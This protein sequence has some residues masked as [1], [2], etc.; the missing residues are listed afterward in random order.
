MKSLKCKICG[1]NGP[2]VL[3]LWVEWVMLPFSLDKETLTNFLNDSISGRIV[4]CEIYYDRWWRVL[5]YFGFY[6][7]TRRISSGEIVFPIH[8]RF[9]ITTHWSQL[10]YFTHIFLNLILE[11]RFIRHFSKN[12]I[13]QRHLNKGMRCNLKLIPCQAVVLFIRYVNIKMY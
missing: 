1:Y 7:I 2:N 3:H 4:H 8:K 12:V 5:V 9:I 11:R 10:H 13:I 6:L